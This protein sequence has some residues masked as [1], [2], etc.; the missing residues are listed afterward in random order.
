MLSPMDPHDARLTK[1]MNA[2]LHVRL[3]HG[4]EL[5]VA[6]VVRSYAEAAAHDESAVPEYL[7]AAA[8]GSGWR[9]NTDD[10]AGLGYKR[11]DLFR[12]LW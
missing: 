9:V 2:L 12:A 5:P 10:L 11:G 1:A 7:V 4:G 3:Q 6:E 8:D